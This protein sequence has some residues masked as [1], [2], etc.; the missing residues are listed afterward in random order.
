M[1]V[2]ASLPMGDDGASA[3]I[4]IHYSRLL[5]WVL[6]VVRNRDAIADADGHH[7]LLTRPRCLA[8]SG[9]ACFL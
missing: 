9:R 7:A 3:D 2:T 4:L 6:V 8:T 5:P 1:E